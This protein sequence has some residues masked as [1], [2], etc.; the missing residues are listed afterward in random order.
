M[1]LG[2][3]EGEDDVTIAASLGLSVQCVGQVYVGAL[4]KLEDA[5]GLDGSMGGADVLRLMRNKRARSADF[6]SVYDDRGNRMGAPCLPFGM[7]AEDHPFPAWGTSRV[8]LE[9]V[10]RI[11]GVDAP[12]LV[13]RT[14][15]AP[16]AAVVAPSGFQ[17]G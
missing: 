14:S 4:R 10:S 2:V 15:E 8:L 7:K 13:I 11:Q 12:R 9:L 17:W 1:I 6:V 16:P 3:A 5:Y